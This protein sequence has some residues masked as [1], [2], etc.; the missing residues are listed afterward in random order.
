MSE[1]PTT[2]SPTADLGRP[3]VDL[4]T[5]DFD[6]PLDE[7]L[8]AQRP[9]AERDASRLLLVRRAASSLD[10]RYFRD[11][12][13]LI[14]PGDV[15]VLNDTRVFPAR[16]LGRKPSGA[17][18]EVL[19]LQPVDGEKRRWRALVRPGGKLKPGRVVRV[20]DS[21][22]VLIEESCEGGARLVAL[23]TPL[24]PL[25]AVFRYGRVPLPPY[26]RR[27][28]DED[29]QVRYQTVY[30][31]ESGSVAAPTAGLHFTRR[32]LEALESRGVE[33]ARITLHVGP[34]TFRPVEESDPARHRLDAE[35][36]RVSAVAA[37][38]INRCRAAGGAVWAAGTTTVRT[39]ET[40]AG[41]N[42]VVEPGAGMTDLFIRPGY[43]FRIVDRLITNFHLPRSTL[44]MLVAA[45]A[46]YERTMAAYRHALERRY[47]FYSYGDAMVVM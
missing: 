43:R 21:L 42:G 20:A 18:A 39:L 1:F 33:I 6:Y 19:L 25:E 45:F 28:D 23:Q 40:V 7:G 32:V 34:G 31:A 12:V 17:E 37:A 14:D 29:D 35:S 26:I 3:A 4:R 27:S 30:A 15:L 22:E 38:T 46:G 9:L 11:L 13:S 24:P 36:Y 44:L 16:L 47:R 41:G 8:I 10:D 2:V 5:E